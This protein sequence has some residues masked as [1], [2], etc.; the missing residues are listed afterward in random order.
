MI[1]NCDCI[2][3]DNRLNSDSVNLGIYD[4]PF[5]IGESKF[6]KHYKRDDKNV[7]QEYKEAPADYAKFTNDWMEEAK[8]VLHPNGSMYVIMGHSNLRHVLN[9]AHSLELNEINH[10]EIQ[11]WSKH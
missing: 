9:V 2:G 8:R 11:F 5:G 4:P 6:D 10:L 7:I 3:K 1:Y